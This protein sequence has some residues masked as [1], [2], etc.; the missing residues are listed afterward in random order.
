MIE[1][2]RLCES[3]RKNNVTNFLILTNVSLLSKKI[4]R[5]VNSDKITFLFTAFQKENI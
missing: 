5:N 1:M 4:K 2:Y 3:F